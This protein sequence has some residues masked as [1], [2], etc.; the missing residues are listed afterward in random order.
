MRFMT[1]EQLRRLRDRKSPWDD[2]AEA[3]ADHEQAMARRNSIR[4]AW[5][6]AERRRRNWQKVEPVELLSFTRRFGWKLL[7]SGVWRRDFRK[8]EHGE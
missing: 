7:K 5:P 4:D 6:E 2:E 1:I 3:E 8:V